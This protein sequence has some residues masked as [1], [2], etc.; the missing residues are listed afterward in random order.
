[1]ETMGLIITDL[2]SFRGTANFGFR[3]ASKLGSSVRGGTNRLSSIVCV[4][5]LAE[6]SGLRWRMAAGHNAFRFLAAPVDER[7]GRIVVP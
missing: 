3:F 6:T 2:I 1:M 7:N 5:G 4:V